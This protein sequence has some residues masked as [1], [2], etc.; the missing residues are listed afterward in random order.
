L[1]KY[2]KKFGLIINIVGFTVVPLLIM[3]TALI[4]FSVS[5]SGL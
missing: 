4:M 3:W 2:P 1:S 5:S